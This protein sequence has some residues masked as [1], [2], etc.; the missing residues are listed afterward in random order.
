[1]LTHESERRCDMAG[2]MSSFYQRSWWSLMIRGILAAIFGIVALTAPAKTLDFLIVLF[3][4]FVL[5][6][7]LVATIGA[8]MHRRE[9]DNWW[10]ILIPGI[11]GIVIGVISIA[12][13]AF[14]EAVIIYLIAIWAL[15]SGIG[16]LYSAMKI[17]KDVEGEWMPIL[18]GI[19]SIVLAVLLFVRPL[20]A[21][22]TVMWLVGLF[23]LVIGILW[24]VMGFRV[25]GWVGRPGAGNP[26]APES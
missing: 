19:V 15:V 16:Q 20:E 8:I 14:T 21:A 10:L 7:G 12:M 18:I 13:P 25:R 9:S 26:V 2:F 24:I 4:I 6:V 17:R 22:A 23:V 3:G 5:V 1:M 11:A